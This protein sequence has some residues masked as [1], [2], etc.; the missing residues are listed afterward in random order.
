M[1]EGYTFENGMTVLNTLAEVCRNTETVPEE[2]KPHVEVAREALEQMLE[3]KETSVTM[4]YDTA[5]VI[6]EFIGNYAKKMVFG[7]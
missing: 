7:E 4:P 1:E 5:R 3:N 6:T 2:V